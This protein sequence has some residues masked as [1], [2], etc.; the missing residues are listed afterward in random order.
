MAGKRGPGAVRLWAVLIWILVFALG[1]AMVYAL[2]NTDLKVEGQGLKVI[3]ASEREELFR[4]QKGKA[5]IGAFEGMVYRGAPD[6]PDGYEYRIYTLRLRNAC[7]VTAR[8]VEFAVHPS[9]GDVLMYQPAQSVSIAPGETVDVSF[10]ILTGT[11]GGDTR[12]IRLTYYLWGNL[13]ETH[14]VYR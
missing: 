9:A 14:Y 6:E 11:G 10:V 1:G 7:L 3:P 8:M 13:C 12:D 4:E 2:L 5:D